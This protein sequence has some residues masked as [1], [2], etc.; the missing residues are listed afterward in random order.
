MPDEEME[1]AEETTQEED[2]TDDEVDESAEAADSEEP[3]EDEE[4][5]ESEDSDEDE[6]EDDGF[7]KFK[8]DMAKKYGDGPGLWD[9][10]GKGYWNQAKSLSEMHK[11]QKAADAKLEAVLKKLDAIHTPKQ[12]SADQILSENP[13]LQQYQQQLTEYESDLQEANAEAQ[14]CSAEAVKQ[15]AA[16]NQLKGEI[17]AAER[18]EDPVASQLK[19]ELRALESEYK[20]TAKS[21]QDAIK[22]ADRINKSKTSHL[23][24]YEV[25]WKSALDSDAKK[26]E[27]SIAEER[28]L[29]DIVER[30]DLRLAANLAELDLDMD[31]E[32]GS[33]IAENVRTQLSAYFHSHPDEDIDVA[34]LTDKFCE[35]HLKMLHKEKATRFSERS[36]AKKQTLRSKV[37]PSPQRPKQRRQDRP[38][39][40]YEAAQQAKAE[41]RRTAKKLGWNVG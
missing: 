12:K 34:A 26:A 25:A 8:A 19:Y 13:D 11:R 32:E 35:R 16:I 27:A 36:K 18:A 30:I 17:R 39:T 24:R 41:A 33:Y 5:E 29:E 37:P 4:S 28:E 14:A 21:Y 31:S 22:R 2:F 40:P 7:A 3:E 38:M 1:T 6:D 15:Q 23:K 9:R 10:V 20:T